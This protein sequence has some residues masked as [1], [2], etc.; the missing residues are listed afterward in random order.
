MA[1]PLFTFLL[2][3]LLPLLPFSS[4]QS[5]MS[6]LHRQLGVANFEPLRPYFMDVFSA[7]HASL[8][9]LQGVPSILTHLDR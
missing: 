3:L 5:A 7:S 4:S 2:L 8:P 9:G 6:L 1:V